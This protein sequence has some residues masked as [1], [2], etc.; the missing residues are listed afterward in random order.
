MTPL[1]GRSTP[2]SHENPTRPVLTHKGSH[3]YDVHARIRE[4]PPGDDWAL[5]VGDSVH[6][7]RSAL[8]HVAWQLALLTT[9]TPANRTQ[10]PIFRDPARFGA[11]GLVRQARDID[12]QHHPTIEGF[13]PFRAQEGPDESALWLLHELDNADKHRILNVVV[14]A[15]RIQAV[16][17]WDRSAGGRQRIYEFNSPAMLQDGQLIGSF[18]VEG[19]P[20]DADLVFEAALKYGVEFDAGTGA[21]GRDVKV[22]LRRCHSVVADAIQTFASALP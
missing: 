20:A 19:K 3:T 4:L 6:N 22:T 17:V 8:D 10:F 1:S 18:T 2:S 7:F 16:G 9:A 12:A 11:E 5:L 21:E 14:H 13:Q 15:F